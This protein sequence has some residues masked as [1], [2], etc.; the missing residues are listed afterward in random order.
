MHGA[1]IRCGDIFHWCGRP[2]DDEFKR[3]GDADHELTLQDLEDM[4]PVFISNITVNDWQIAGGHDNGYQLM[5][6]SSEG[7]KVI[8]SDMKIGGVL[9]RHFVGRFHPHLMKLSVAMAVSGAAV[10]FDKEGY[11]SRLDVVLDLFAL[12]GIQMGEEIVC[13]ECREAEIGWKQKVCDQHRN[14][15]QQDCVYHDQAL[16]KVLYF[17]FSKVLSTSNL[18]DQ[19]ET[20]CVVRTRVPRRKAI[21]ICNEGTDKELAPSHG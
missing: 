7:V 14:Y 3:V 21:I 10:S 20:S 18:R 17:Q 8:G 4:S 5:T 11:Q 1:K 13:D 2:T 9:A 6:F 19:F 12:M 16:W 15:Y